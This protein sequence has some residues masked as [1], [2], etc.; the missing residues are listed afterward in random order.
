MSSIGIQIYTPFHALVFVNRYVLGAGSLHGKESVQD[1]ITFQMDLS[2]LNYTITLVNELRATF[3]I[4]VYC[5]MFKVPV[6]CLF[7]RKK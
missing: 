5:Y 4:T 7:A 6:F 2:T 3:T 1:M